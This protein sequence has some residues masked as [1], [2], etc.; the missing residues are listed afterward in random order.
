[1]SNYRRAPVA[2][3]TYFFTLVLADRHLD[4]LVSHTAALRTAYRRARNLH[5]FATIS[6][7]YGS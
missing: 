2:G 1:M 3:A 4:L 6:M 7:R 5:P